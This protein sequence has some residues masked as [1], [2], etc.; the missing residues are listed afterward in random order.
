MINDTITLIFRSQLYNELLP[1]LKS[2]VK[3]QKEIID[4]KLFGDMSPSTVRSTV[5]IAQFIIVVSWK[6]LAKH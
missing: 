6:C 5:T 1:E 2:S 4:A 3:H